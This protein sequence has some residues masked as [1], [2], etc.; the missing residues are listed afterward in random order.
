MGS[1]PGD[2][3]VCSECGLEVVVAKACGC[4]DDCVL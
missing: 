3:L 4:G 2:V 1:K